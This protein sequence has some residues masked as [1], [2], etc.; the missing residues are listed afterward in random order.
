[1]RKLAL[2]TLVAALTLASIAPAL[3]AA[4]TS[5]NFNVT[6]TLTS[7]CQQTNNASTTVAFGTYV[8]FQGAAQPSSTA[9]LTF[10]CTRG[11]ALVSTVFDTTLPTSTSAGVGVIQGLQYT[12]S[13]AT[14]VNV[15]GAVAS[16]TS[17]GSGDI[18]TYAITG[19]MP[20][21][22]AGACAAA[23][24]GVTSQ[25]RTLVLTF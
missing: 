15:A 7:Q 1:M 10:R 12:L 19:T 9:N 14:A 3:Q 25:V 11:Y 13:A 8:A 22:Q 24:C 6:V 4:T 2:K 16:S 17:I 23:S 18:L 5:N 21:D 20:A